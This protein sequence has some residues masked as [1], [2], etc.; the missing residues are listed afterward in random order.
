MTDSNC[1]SHGIRRCSFLGLESLI[2]R[3]RPSVSQNCPNGEVGFQRTNKQLSLRSRADLRQIRQ[4]PQRRS[5]LC[6]KSMSN[7]PSDEVGLRWVTHHR[8]RGKVDHQRSN[9]I[10][11]H[12][13]PTSSR[14]STAPPQGQGRPP[15]KQHHPISQ[16]ADLQQNQHNTTQKQGRPP[17]KQHHPISQGVDFQQIKH[18]TVPKAGSTTSEVTSS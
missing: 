18:N 17:A 14:S 9:I 7:R 5:R 13:A 15:A 4:P 1:R 10:P 8:P 3:R 11:H 6:C 12:K 16:D 2:A